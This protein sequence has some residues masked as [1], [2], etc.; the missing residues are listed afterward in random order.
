MIDITKAVCDRILDQAAVTAIVSAQVFAQ[1]F[2]PKFTPP[3][4]RVQRIG[5]VQGGHLRGTS[6]I[7]RA[8]VQVDSVGSSRATA[9]ALDEAVF[10]DGVATG[11]A[12]FHGAMSG[13]VITCAM[14]ESVDEGYDPDELKQY[15]IRRDYMVTWKNA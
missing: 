5:E 4:V 6:N 1:N 14:P 10:G 7:R 11:L 8:R 13:L 12:N 9:V 3:G 15:R 2:P